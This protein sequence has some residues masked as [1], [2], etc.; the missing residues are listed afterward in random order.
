MF[1]FIYYF[2]ISFFFFL[3]L[4]INPNYWA[5]F[6]NSLL[7]KENNMFGFHFMATILTGRNFC[8]IYYQILTSLR[9]KYL[10]ALYLEA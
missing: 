4:I 5:Y 7:I 9:A 3:I 1:F 2:S 8:N 10:P 6:I